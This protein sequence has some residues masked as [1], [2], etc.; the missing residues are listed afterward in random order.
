MPKKE[1]INPSPTK[2]FSAKTALKPSQNKGIK[3]KPK[4]LPEGASARK[5][6]RHP[7]PPIQNIRLPVPPGSHGRAQIGRVNPSDG[8]F[9]LLPE[10]QTNPGSEILQAAGSNH[11]PPRAKPETPIPSLD[12]IQEKLNRT[13]I[14]MQSP[15]GSNYPA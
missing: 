6:S 13:Q 12:A 10:G 2:A 7:M 3:P 11:A 1:R 8:L 9:N 5:E 14:K 4:T 15:I